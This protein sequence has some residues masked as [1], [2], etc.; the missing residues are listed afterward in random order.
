MKS[1][2]FTVLALLINLVSCGDSYN[3]RVFQGD[4]GFTE[5]AQSCKAGCFGIPQEWYDL[6]II[7]D[8]NG[9][10]I[11]KIDNSVKKPGKCYFKLCTDPDSSYNKDAQDWI[12]KHGGEIVIDDSDIIKCDALKSV[13][14]ANFNFQESSIDFLKESDC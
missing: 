4:K 5:D 10:S 8:V 1:V 9:N 3:S 7:I 14:P 11:S 6:G 12:D 2:H 13:Q